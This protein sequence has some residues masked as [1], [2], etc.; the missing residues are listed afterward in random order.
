MSDLG[1]NCHDRPACHSRA[2]AWYQY[3][4]YWTRLSFLGIKIQTCSPGEEQCFHYNSDPALGS[5]NK[6][7]VSMMSIER[8]VLPR[9]YHAVVEN[10]LRPCG[11]VVSARCMTSKSVAGSPV[12]PENSMGLGNGY[13]GKGAK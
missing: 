4:R 5:C 7:E 8:R 10:T 6:V 9:P 13:S 2:S 1:T 11:V 12:E 3:V